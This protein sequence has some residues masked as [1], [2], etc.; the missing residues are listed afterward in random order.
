MTA[1]VVFGSGGHAR[2][3]ADVVRACIDSGQAFDLLGFLDDDERRHGM[4]LVDLPVLGGQPWLHDHPDVAVVLGVGSPASKRRIATQLQERQA[5][6]ASVVHPR[7]EITRYVELGPGVVITAG[8]VLTNRIVLG[9]HVHLNRLCTV[10]HDCVVG[11]YCHIAPGAVLSGNVSLGEGCEIGTG[12]SI[13][14][15]LRIGAWSVVGAGAAVVRDLPAG[16]TAVG[17]PA[18]VIKRNLAP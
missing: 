1:I 4:S 13:I 15:D 17:V 11:D 2:E 18:R 16:V 12:A 3:I 6:F 5:R 10:G 7:A 9:A 14:Q 8:V